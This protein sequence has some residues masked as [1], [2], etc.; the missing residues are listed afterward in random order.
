MSW[1]SVVDEH[2]V[3]PTAGVLTEPTPA[4]D[5]EPSSVDPSATTPLIAP[6]P[7]EP[8]SFAPLALTLAS[9]E[10]SPRVVPPPAAVPAPT[11]APAALSAELPTFEPLV[12]QPLPVAAAPAVE[13]VVE[14]VVQAPPAPA[15]PPVP[16]VL[17]TPPVP[18]VEAAP[19]VVAKAAPTPEVTV[20]PAP[21][22]EAAPAPVVVAAPAPVV[23]AAPAPVVK[24]APA[25]VVTVAPAPAGDTVDPAISDELPVIVEATPVPDG[26]PLAG[27]G[28]AEVAASEP[29]MGGP[30][31]PHAHAARVQAAP[32]AYEMPV[33]ATAV[34]SHRHRRKARGG[35]KLLAMLVILGALVGVGV[36]FGRPYLFPSGFDEATKPYAE[37]VEGASGVQFT[38]T[39]AVIAE[40]TDGLTARLGSE[41]VGDWSTD[42]SMWRAFGL[43]NGAATPQ[44]VTELFAGWQDAIYSTTD[45]QVYRDVSLT[46][47]Q[48]D[49][50][51]T[52][53]VAAASL[54]QQFRWSSQQDSRTLDDQA[55]T[56]A[57]VRRQSGAILAAT[58]FAAPVDP[59][60][61]AVLA[62]VPPL[63]GYGALAPEV[64]A[65]FANTVTSNPLERMGT[66][67]PG[68]LPTELPV[69]APSPVLAAG[70]TLATTPR[71]MDR[72]FWYLVFAGFLD[73]RTAFNASESVIENSVSIADRA[74]AQCVYAT[75]AGGDVAGT[76]VLRAAIEAWAGSAPV[77]FGASTAVL[78][79]GTLQLVSCDPGAGF[80][81]ANRL[82]VAHELVG[83]RS[84]ELATREFVATAGGGEAEF[85]AAWAAVQSSSIGTDLAALPGDTTAPEVAAAA[86][87]AVTSL[88]TPAG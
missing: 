45:G 57:E 42:A 86:R 35:I 12:L 39:I 9:S 63:V 8:I 44:S 37:A 87:S 46:G 29:Y 62:F 36:V 67:G 4:P 48:V 18:V 28:V 59:V 85:A 31:L 52:E 40:P 23:E 80:E 27:L 51:I 14:A 75:F 76:D 68:P 49:A 3:L 74:G 61:P 16:S 24:V 22:V 30:M 69:V 2:D 17:E 21:V 26:A 81:N 56:L 50:Q 78:A 54:D 77:E 83:W 71:A 6:A 13:S 79:D 84:A 64:F 11:P 82:G 25:P 5:P 15:A 33:A 58:S 34:G 47:A 7:I 65:Q 70:D 73:S 55:Q 19:D 43:L 60:A 72:S 32:L 66:G 1:E 88:L 53:A 41:L 38:D 20:S 10:P